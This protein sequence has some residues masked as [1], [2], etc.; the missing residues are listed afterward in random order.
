MTDN[1]QKLADELEQFIQA[2]EMGYP[3]SDHSI[4]GAEFIVALQT[5]SNETEPAPEFVAELQTR[6][7]AQAIQ[8]EQKK[9]QTKPKPLSFWQVLEHFLKDTLT[10]KYTYAFTAFVVVALL[11]VGAI[12]GRDYFMT[13][14]STEPSLIE[15]ETSTDQEVANLV[16]LPRLSDVNNT[17][18][19]GADGAATSG[20]VV[21]SESLIMDEPYKM[22]ASNPFI[23][24]Q[25]VL[26]TEL[27]LDSMNGVV[28]QRMEQT[29]I[30]AT[31]AR[32]IANQLGFSGPLYSET[33]DWGMEEEAYIPPATYI[34]FDGAKSL[35]ISPWGISYADQTAINAL[36]HNQQ[37]PFARAAEVAEAFLEEHGWLDFPYEIEEG[38]HN[39]LFFMRI[40]DGFVT[41]EPEIVVTVNQ[42][43]Q[44]AYVY[45]NMLNDWAFVG[46]YPLITAE[47]AWQNLLTNI[48]ND[49]DV[50]YRISYTD[51][52]FVLEEMP[53]IDTDYSYWERQYSAG[54]EVHLYE[55]VTVFQPV[56]GGAPLVKTTQF[57]IQ[58]DDMTLATL[59]ENQG[60]QLHL[61]GT[62]NEEGNYLQLTGWE[63]VPEESGFFYERGTLR[64][65]NGQWLF[66][67][68]NEAIYALLDVPADVSNELDVYVFAHTMRDAGLAYPVLE[69][70]GI[71]SYV[72]YPEIEIDEDGLIEEDYVID[73]D[74]LIDEPLPVDILPVEP[75]EPFSYENVQINGVSLVYMVTYMQP[76]E[77]EATDDMVWA[78]PTIYLQP[79]WQ[80]AG[81]A[82]N[83]DEVKLFVQAVA[84]EYLQ[85]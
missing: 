12:F 55:W 47:E 82:E 69:W 65:E 31:L 43:G 34:V 50:Q 80:F 71:E 79:V 52:P 49:Y 27:P 32:Q 46:N 3:T 48:G 7:Q 66:Y 81:I 10:M 51:D 17:N 23:N 37:T 63:L 85:P 36:D 53:E 75:Y 19:S 4:E 20:M 67:G 24:A 59:A 29:Q 22:M 14:D 73:E 64:Q 30:D 33:Y 40:V 68:E 6:L 9:I 15:N 45:D 16:P 54:N 57:T 56:E 72:E 74:A 62:I 44:I 60:R 2:H 5:M 28:Q 70:V 84:D 18:V 39:E 25:L 76:A 77:F 1:E 58:A 8:L 83:G 42:M 38:S 61:W 11:A 41:N 13:D 26:N 78:T 35:H 21:E